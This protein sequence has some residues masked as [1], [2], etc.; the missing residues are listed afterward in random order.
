MIRHRYIL[1]RE[2]LH[3]RIEKPERLAPQH[4]RDLRT[5]SRRRRVLVH[6]EASARP[7]HRRQH[8]LAIP[9]RDRAEI[10][11]V[12]VATEP[13]RRIDA[14]MH[15]GTPRHHRDT[16][17]L[18]QPRRAPEGQHVVVARIS[19]APLAGHEQRTM[20]EEDRGIAA[21]HRRAEQPHRI[22]R[23]RRHRHL[24][25]E[26]M[27]PRHFR[28]ER[29]PRV[30]D[31]LA[32]TS[33]HAHHDRRREPVGRAPPHGTD[34]VELLVRRIRVLPELDLRHGHQAT[35]GHP[36]R[37]ANDA[38]L[39]QARVEDA[40]RT[41]P[42]LQPF[43]HE[44]HATL[45]THILAEHEHPGIGLEFRRERTPH[46]LRQ[47]HHLAVGGGHVGATECAALLARQS[48]VR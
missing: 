29:M 21:P 10:Q 24:P 38:L 17:T 35:H 15:H 11:E 36:D 16:R 45:A 26:C 46:G 44:V 13:V 7:A 42:L 12:H 33:R 34:V 32:E 37:S 3:R 19:R 40:L 18:A 1:H 48:A 28:R 14:P 25:A 30:A 4:G 39:G 2:P 41:E 20:L 23:V 5:E 6:D 31:I 47:P 43:G 22:R 27:G 8:R 9:G